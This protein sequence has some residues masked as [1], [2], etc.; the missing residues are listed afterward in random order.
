MW[1]D[2]Y[3]YSNLSVFAL[4][5]L[6][7]NLEAIGHVPEKMADEIAAQ[8]AAVE[9]RRETH[10]AGGAGRARPPTPSTL[11]PATSRAK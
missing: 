6:Y 8:L 7:L 2:S 4:H 10:H 11:P 1:W 5:P 3:P 9:E